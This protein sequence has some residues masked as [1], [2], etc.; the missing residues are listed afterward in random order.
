MLRQKNVH[1]DYVY[2]CIGVN[3]HAVGRFK[4]ACINKFKNKVI[5]I[6]ICNK[7]NSSTIGP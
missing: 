5:Y 3:K 2:T 4:Y 7:N 6:L 1:S